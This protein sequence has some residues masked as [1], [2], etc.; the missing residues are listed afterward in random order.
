M[1]SARVGLFA[2]NQNSFGIGE[3][4]APAHAPVHL[5]PEDALAQQPRLRVEQRRERGDVAGMDRVDRCAKRRIRDRTRIE[6]RHDRGL[7]ARAAAARDVERRAAFAIGL[8][9]ER[10]ALDERLDERERAAA[11]GRVQRRLAPVV[12][13]RVRAAGE[14]RAH[15]V[16]V[17]VAHRREERR[18]RRGGVATH[19]RN[20]P[21]QFGPVRKSVIRGDEMLRGSEA[22]GT[23]SR[24]AFRL[25][26]Q[27][28]ARRARGKRRHGTSS[29]ETPDVRYTGRKGR[30]VNTR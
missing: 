29:P 15:G 16:D 18:R 1:I 17:A 28:L 26:A 11:R 20:V 13:A 8:P 23:F 10:A 25:F 2:T 27:M 22:G 9:L 19:R 5:R 21:H 24:K 4:R 14:Q 6:Q 12:Q 7:L 3:V 30:T